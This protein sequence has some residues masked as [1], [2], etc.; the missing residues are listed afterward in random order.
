VKH[1][2]GLS[3]AVVVTGYYLLALREHFLIGSQVLPPRVA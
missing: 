2:V 1:V 3:M